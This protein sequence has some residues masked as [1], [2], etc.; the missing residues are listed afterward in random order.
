MDSRSAPPLSWGFV[1]NDM[2]EVRGRAVE[3]SAAHKQFA[4]ERA[5]HEADNKSAIDQP[6]ADK[7]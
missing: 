4:D 5:R 6:P 1:G 2:P 7:Q 3:M